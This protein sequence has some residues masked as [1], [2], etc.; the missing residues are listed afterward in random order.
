MQISGLRLV[1]TDKSNGAAVRMGVRP[2]HLVLDLNGQLKG[3][4]TLVERLG[5][6]TVVEL[7]TQDGTPFRFAG[8]DVPEIEVGQD[9]SFGFDPSLAHLF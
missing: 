1:A 3:T 9:L 7:R 2:Q 6:E 4:V 5:T 8:Q